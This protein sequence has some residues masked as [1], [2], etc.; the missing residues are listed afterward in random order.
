MSTDIEKLIERLRRWLDRGDSDVRGM[1]TEAADAL[2]RLVAPLPAEVE[3]MCRYLDGLEDRAPIRLLESLAREN[4]RLA[5]E[6]ATEREAH[7]CAIRLNNELGAERDRLAAEIAELL[8]D[9]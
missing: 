6:N 9:V 5:A 1:V 4:A 3:A 2:T 7:G 8:K